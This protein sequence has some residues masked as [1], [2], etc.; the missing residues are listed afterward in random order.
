MSNMRSFFGKGWGS[1]HLEQPIF[2]CP[3]ERI[4]Q[5]YKKNENGR[6]DR[7][8]PPTES[9][10]GGATC[11]AFGTSVKTKRKHPRHP[12]LRIVSRA[13]GLWCA[14]AGLVYSRAP[15]CCFGCCANC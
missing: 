5:K 1:L 14:R 13:E 15:G 3:D 2:P 9:E 4:N 10:S 7:L 12:T 11:I 8:V 6:C